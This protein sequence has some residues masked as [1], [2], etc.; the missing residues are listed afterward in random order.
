MGKGAERDALRAEF[1]AAAHHLQVRNARKGA[2]ERASGTAKALDAKLDAAEEAVDAQERAEGKAMDAKIRGVR[3]ARR[4]C[5]PARSTQLPQPAITCHRSPL[6]TAHRPSFRRAK[7]V[8]EEKASAVYTR[9][10]KRQSGEARLSAAERSAKAR[11]SAASQERQARRDALQKA[12]DDYARA[13]S[14]KKALV[15]GIRA[16]ARAEREAVLN[17]NKAHAAKERANDIIA[18]QAKARVLA[19]KRASAERVKKAGTAPAPKLRQLSATE[20][21]LGGAELGIVVFAEPG[22]GAGG[23]GDEPGADERRAVG[24]ERGGGCWTG[25]VAQLRI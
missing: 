8:Y 1:D 2:L 19:E 22:A 7:R 6:I 20:A 5:L 25:C 17:A 15:E 11:M 9:T 4:R 18:V 16:Q 12:K 10:F 13:S 3:G 14:E 24:R 21:K 23:P